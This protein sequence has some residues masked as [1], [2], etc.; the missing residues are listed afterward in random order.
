MASL[1][2]IN[3]P[4]RET[5]SNE[6][7]STTINNNGSHAKQPQ[8]IS[9]PRRMRLLEGCDQIKM[10]KLL[11]NVTFPRSLGVVKLVMSPDAT[12]ADLIRTAVG[13]YVREKRRPLLIEPVDT[14][15]FQLHYS[16]FTFE[17]LDP[18]QKLMVMQSRSC[19]LC[20]KPPPW[21]SSAPLVGYIE[22]DRIY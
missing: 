14:L 22:L 1:S 7:P 21:L 4:G 6:Q 8:L 11:L 3:I 17:C 16:P 15:R 20:T 19:F 13:I 12:V 5:P 18:D 10:N 9:V 2:L